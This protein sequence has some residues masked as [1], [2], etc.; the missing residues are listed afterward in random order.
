MAPFMDPSHPSD[1]TWQATDDAALVTVFTSVLVGSLL[2]LP[3]AF[4]VDRVTAS[5]TA[6]FT[7]TTSS[8]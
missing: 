5:L 8:R 7:A 1:H 2:L 3:A 4:L 6:G